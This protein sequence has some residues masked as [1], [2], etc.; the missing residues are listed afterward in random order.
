M[1]D[2]VVEGNEHTARLTRESSTLSPPIQFKTFL[3]FIFIDCSYQTSK[4][5]E[6]NDIIYI[7]TNFKAFIPSPSI[8]VEL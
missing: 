4:S 5:E 1:T 7:P 6:L 8:R 3:G 2:E